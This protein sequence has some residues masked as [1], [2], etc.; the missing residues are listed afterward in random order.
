MFTHL[1]TH[2]EFSLLDGACRIEQLVSRAKSLGMQSLAITDHG[3][4]YGAVDFYKAC[5]KEGIKPVIGCEVYVAPRTRFDKDKVLDKEYNHLILLCENETGYKNLINMVSRAFTEGFYFKP[6]IDHDLLEKHHEGLICLSACLAGEIP[7]A[8]LQKDYEKAKRTALWYRDV[9]GEGN[10]YLE[11]Q[12]HGLSEQL[13][14]NEGVKRISRETGIPLAATNDVHYINKEDA[15]IQ[16]VLICIATNH[17]I[18]DDTGLEFHADEFYLKS[19]E[20]M[21]TLFADTPEAIDNTQ[22]IAD[23]CDFEFEFGNTKLPYYE[24]PDN[25]D[26]FEYFKMLCL[27]GMKKRYGENP[28]QEYYDR[29]DYELNT[30]DKM[31][32][33][34]YYLI[35]SDFVSFAKSKDIPVGP[36][37]GS[38]AGSI[39]AYCMGIT[40][41]DPMKYNLLFERFLNPERVSMPDFD[42]DF[43]YERRGEVIEYVTNKYGADHVAQIVTFGTLATRAAIRDVGRAMGM[44][45]ASV[46]AVAKLVPNDFHITIE[47]AVS[48]SKELAKLMQENP[49]VNELIET[50]KKV[51][52][53]PRNTSTHAAGVV[54][55]HNP[56]SSYVPLATNDG[57]PVTQYIMTTLEELGLLKMDFLG[58][59][60]LTVIDDAAKA[61]GVDVDS[62][63]IDDANVYK[64]FARGQTEGI[65]QFESSGMKQML[66]NLKP[67]ALEDLI[68]ATSLYRP[69]PAKQIDT[70]VENSHNP[71]NVKYITDKLRPILENTYGCMVYQEQVMQIFREL[72]DYSYGRA[73]IVRR[74]MSKK[75]ISVMEQE[76]ETFILGCEKNGIDKSAANTIFDQMSDFAKYA[77]N[78]S[79]AAC[80]ALVAYRTAYLKYYYP[81]E[82]MA[83]LMTSVL[84]QSNKI[85]RYTAECKRIGL[86]L[87]PPNINSSMKGFTANGRVINYGLLGIKNVGSDFIDEI[88]EERKTGPFTDLTDFCK[89]MQEG[90]F[91]RRAA[92]SLIRCGAMDC[93]GYN[94]RQLLQALPAL[95]TNLENYRQNTRY[96][97]VGFFDLGQGDIL[98]FDV[99]IPDVSEFPKAELLKME[100]EMTGLYLSGH[101]MDKHAEACKNLGYA[102]TIDLLEAE[103]DPMSKYKDKC[104]VKLCGIITR[105][106]LK[107]TRN[108]GTMAFVTAEDLYGSIEIIV[109]P[110][111]LEKYSEMIYD[112]NVISV[113]GNL[114]LEEQKDAKILASE[115][116][117]PPTGASAQ[118]SNSVDN[119][120]KKKKKRGLFL[121]FKSETDD[122]IR[123]AK[124]VTAIFDGTI[125]LYFYYIDSG[126]YEL[127]PR[128]TFVEVN[129]TE[130]KELKRI[131]GD[132]N[133]VYI[134]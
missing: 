103:K 84:D 43:C 49:Q 56:V 28:P 125:P 29:L 47:Q 34:D 33:T 75:K 106:T 16:Q 50:A 133:V 102:Y 64:L 107:Q 25:M 77:F 104:L 13:A 22:I 62:M 18:G 36:G 93:F 108:G 129:E 1:H 71:S 27:Q 55:T 89:R 38:G 59:R 23:R 130:L 32:Y 63:P 94:R 96:G 8:I 17:V 21:R 82:F 87:G 118:Q 98:S 74:A 7:Q 15:K 57:V 88:V 12:N 81:S 78:K 124:R 121:R 113:V 95:V 86:R 30:V 51:E 69:G 115:L 20:E 39:A 119:A 83:A 5:K 92:E 99:E 128:N 117:P 60:T 68:A 66:T 120:N 97:Q 19:E 111:T 112:G 116:A 85:A 72:A 109:F 91:N 4:M 6:R 14:V 26:H 54:I 10:Y 105:T 52:G 65:F 24:T 126:K 46:D 80:Y 61:A 53:M 101:P 42:I 134:G 48:K 3:N 35:V 44:P 100:K 70:F 76:R 127:Q 123:L 131:L 37:R 73:D 41:L 67:T 2:T 122:N 45:Y 79:H 9:F 110:K 40:D 11:L 132:E 90:H 31:G 58:L 114:S